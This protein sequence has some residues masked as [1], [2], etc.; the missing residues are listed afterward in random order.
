MPRWLIVDLAKAMRNAID[1]KAN[2]VR[3]G[4]Q[5]RDPETLRYRYSFDVDWIVSR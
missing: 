1:V 3:W 5:T 2:I 4:N